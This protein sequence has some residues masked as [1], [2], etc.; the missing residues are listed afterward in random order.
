MLKK[1]T[2]SVSGIFLFLF[3]INIISRVLGFFREILF[4]YFFGTQQE[5]D[6]YLIAA[7]IPTTISVI[8]LYIGQNYFIPAF[9][10]HKKNNDNAT[11]F[12]KSNMFIF[13]VAGLCLTIL[14]F[15]FTPNII[16]IF[17]NESYGG[18]FNL[19]QDIF[20]ILLIILPISAVISI[21]SAY[22]LSEMDFISPAVSRLFL[23][24]AIIPVIWFSSKNIGIYSISIGLAIGIL[25]Q[26]IYLF[27]KLKIKDKWQLKSYV[28]N[29]N[30]LGENFKSVI[31]III[32]IESISQLYSLSD[33][34]FYSSV[35]SGGIASLN[36][37]SNIFMLPISIISVSIATIIFSKVSEHFA[38]QSKININS[39]ISEFLRVNFIIF[40]FT[41]FILLLFGDVIVKIIFERGKFGSSDST[42][43]FNL[44]KIFSISLLFY[45]T[46]SLYNKILYSAKLIKPLFII[47][48]L[49]I[50][51]KIILNFLLVTN[52]KQSGLALSTT[53]SYL[54]FFAS[55]NLIIKYKL[56]IKSRDN[57][58]LLAIYYS[59]NIL[60]AYLFSSLF[61]S[62]LSIANT[63]K[64][65]IMLFTF[66][67]IY[68]INLVFLQD[69]ILDYLKRVRT[70]FQ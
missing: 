14:F 1:L 45:S 55:S 47:T 68:I 56:K 31:I 3:F 22:F 66:T 4:A 7:V 27:L 70:S 54:F 63:Q 28:K 13:F 35:D 38:G 19:A 64:S 67:I 39:Y 50:M 33:R 61:I 46:Y 36:Y 49:G 40:L 8:I 25:L 53:I 10:S 34:F 21:I 41:T 57:Y 15:L 11:E 42:S 26:F 9:H 32:I 69:S 23:N 29:W 12:L 37:A 5:F 43:T 51:L 58:I 24:I 60:V 17:I 20:K 48:V 18:Y 52:F 6:V 62:L 30:K 65:I 59:T 16:S 44:L 2:S